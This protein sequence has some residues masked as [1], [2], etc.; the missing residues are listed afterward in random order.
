MKR[1]ITLSSPLGG[2][3]CGKDTPCDGNILLPELINVL[4]SDLVYSET[5]QSL[6]GPAQYWRD[7]FQIDNFLLNS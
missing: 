5:I 7:P 4:L 6:I 2:F 3:F 1:L